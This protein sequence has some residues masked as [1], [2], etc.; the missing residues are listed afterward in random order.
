MRTYR[1][2]TFIGSLSSTSINRTLAKAL[3]R[4]A[5]DDLEFTEIPI[6]NLPL[7]SPDFDDAYPPEAT[8]LKEAIA[9]SDAVL[10]VTPEYNRSIPGA[11][12]NAIDWASRPWG[13]NSFDHIPAAVIGASPGQIGTAVAQQSLRAVLSF[14][15]ARQM[16]APEG[17]ITFKPEVYGDDGSIADEGT[18]QFLTEFMAEF[19]DY[20]ERVL[21]VLP[22]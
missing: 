8:A 1:V 18:E 17:Y 14:C 19:R 6:G 15:N 12:K 21:T 10:F 11:L 16:T 13:Q 4:V 2:G 5:P 3:M 22:R 7:Y 20:M 9:A